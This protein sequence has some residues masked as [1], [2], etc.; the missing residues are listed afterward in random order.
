MKITQIKVKDIL[1]LEYKKIS[2][3][4]H[5]SKAKGIF[6]EED[7]YALCVY[8]ENNGF[9]GLTT[10][11]NLAE[12]GVP[13]HT[14]IKSLIYNPPKIK[15][16]DAFVD[17]A[18]KVLDSGYDA[19]PIFDND[20]VIG[21]L[22]E[23][24]IIDIARKADELTD[25]KSKK[26]TDEVICIGV[27]EDIGKA[28]HIMHE[29]GVSRLP[30]VDT[31]GKLE[32]V[33]T[34]KDIMKTIQPNERMGDRDVAGEKIPHYEIPISS[35]MNDKPLTID[36]DTN[37][38]TAAEQMNKKRQYSAIIVKNKKPLGIITPK[39]TIEFIASLKEKKGVYLQ[40]TGMPDVDSFVVSKMHDT[41]DKTVQ[42]IGRI[43]EG[44]EYLII[45][46]K[47]HNKG[48]KQT[49]YTIRTRFMTPVGIFVSKNWGWDLLTAL[50]KALDNLERQVINDHEKRKDKRKR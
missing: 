46:I 40:I 27:G 17:A 48:G 43:Y 36:E 35:I 22:T 23:Y 26:Y 33:V 9:I 4:E 11:R 7:V 16:E 29:E 12:R 20:E 2:K 38:K 15:P 10:E 37:L 19:A 47:E 25:Q 1:P 18:K 42:K 31:E 24:N 5:L 44:L 30:V 39:D 32:G 28:R 21:V 13:A 41:V 8:D 50:D 6:K 3:E 45:H 34:L 49:K 14:K